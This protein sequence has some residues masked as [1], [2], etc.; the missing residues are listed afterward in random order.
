MIAKNLNGDLN[1]FVDEARNKLIHILSYSEVSIDYA[2][3]DLPSNMIFDM[4][5][6]LSHIKDKLENIKKSSDKRLTSLDGHK[7]SIIG[8]PNVGKSSLLN[9]LLE[10]ERAIISNEAGTTR[11]TIEEYIKLS[12]KLVKIIDTAGVR[13]SDNNIEN[14]GI[15]K[16]IDCIDKAD[17]IV[18]LFDSSRSLDEDDEKILSLIKEYKLKKEIMIVFSKCDLPCKIDTTILSTDIKISCID[19]NINSLVQKLEDFLLMDDSYNDIILTSQRQ[20][21][22]IKNCIDNIC[23]SVEFLENEELEFFSYH[24]KEALESIS[25]IT[26]VFEYDELLDEIFGNFCLGK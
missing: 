16:T 4:K 14:M 19:K 9:E 12:G 13:N 25:S 8:K 10:Y 22:S 26:K 5:E 6:Q 20:I 1:K 24:I 23:L 18:A 15:K 17:I 7:I 2:T 11:D 3:E 21:D